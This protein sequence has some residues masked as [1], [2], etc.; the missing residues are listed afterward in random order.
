MTNIVSFEDRLIEKTANMVA[1]VFI[2]SE[3]VDNS[4]LISKIK[5]RCDKHRKIDKFYIFSD[6]MIEYVGKLL[7]LTGEDAIID[8]EHM[9]EKDTSN[10][11][12]KK[13]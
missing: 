4:K 2:N 13:F 8:T 1:N 12:R 3:C 7:E 9:F 5:E 10:Q 11:K 6:D